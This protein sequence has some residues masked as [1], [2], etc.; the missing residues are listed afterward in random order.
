MLSYWNILNCNFILPEQ[1]FHYI[2]IYILKKGAELIE[3][4]IYSFQE[5]NKC[6]V[7]CL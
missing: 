1:A 4:S 5:L 3:A 2:N 6:Y 7:P